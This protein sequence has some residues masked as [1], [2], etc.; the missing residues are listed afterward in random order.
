MQA[1]V[2]NAHLEVVHETLE[3]GSA[4]NNNNDENGH[5]VGEDDEHIVGNGNVENG[6]GA[7]SIDHKGKGKARA[8]QDDPDVAPA[9]TREIKPSGNQQSKD[10]SP[11]EFFVFGGGEEDEANR[12]QSREEKEKLQKKVD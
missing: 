8:E 11:L 4:S 2:Y 12:H 3:Q 5:A 7:G 6:L 1:I 10:L 9:M